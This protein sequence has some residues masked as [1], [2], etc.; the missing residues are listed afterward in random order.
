MLVLIIIKAGR[1]W[2]SILHYEWK[3]KV[4]QLKANFCHQ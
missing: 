2:P 4:F 1:V 3:F